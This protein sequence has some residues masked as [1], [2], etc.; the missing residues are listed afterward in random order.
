M[1]AVKATMR[2]IH[3]TPEEVTLAIDKVLGTRARARD[4]AAASAA[5]ADW[6]AICARL[7]AQSGIPA[8]E[9]M[10]KRSGAYAILAYNDL[11]EFARA[12]SGGPGGGRMLDELDDAMTALRL[13]SARIERR[14]KEVK[15]G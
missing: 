14:V 12:Y 5:A 4:R 8:E 13:V 11:H 2:T 10:W 3:A 7:E 1:R 6:A 15:N 9:W